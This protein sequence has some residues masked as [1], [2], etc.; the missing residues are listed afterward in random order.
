[1]QFTIARRMWQNKA[2]PGKR[3]E[4]EEPMK[5]EP[6]SEALAEWAN[7]PRCRGGGGEGERSGEWC[8]PGLHEVSRYLW[9]YGRGG[10][11]QSTDNLE[12]HSVCPLVGIGTPL[13]L[14]LFRKRVCF[15]P[16]PK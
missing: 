5:D 1:M 15:P 4:G 3:G 2:F 8:D 16:E 9:M 7:P 12:Y 13:S 10:E 11:P 14:S 6:C